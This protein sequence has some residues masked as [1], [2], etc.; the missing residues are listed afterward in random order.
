V[1][2]TCIAVPDPI[3]VAQIALPIPL[4]PMFRGV[5]LT[6]QWLLLDPLGNAAGIAVSNGLA[7][8]LH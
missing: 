4:D 6:N 7:F 1:L 2:L 8:T 5:P 3:G